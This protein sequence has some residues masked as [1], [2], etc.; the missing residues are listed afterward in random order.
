MGRKTLGEKR[1]RKRGSLEWTRPF[2]TNYP[3]TQAMT[4]LPEPAVSSPKP[5]APSP[6]SLS[7]LPLPAFIPHPSIVPPPSLLSS[8]HI[9]LARK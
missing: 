2:T 3:E 6:I 9:P 5:T 7:P 4:R 1:R 8:S